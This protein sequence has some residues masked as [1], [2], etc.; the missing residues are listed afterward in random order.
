M[1]RKPLALVLVGL[2][3]LSASMAGCRRSSAAPPLEELTTEEEAAAVMLEA[4]ANTEEMEQAAVVEEAPAATEELAE[5]PAET[6]AETPEPA[7]EAEAASEPAVT[8]APVEPATEEPAAEPVTTVGTDAT[9]HVVQ[10]GENLFQI[11]LRYAITVQAISQANN[12]TNPGLI[13]VGQTLQIPGG[14]GTTA[15]TTTP[16]QTCA[17]VYV[18]Q[19]GDNLFRI[20]LSYDYSQYYLAEYNGLANASM[21]YVGQ[22]LCIP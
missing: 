11:S 18:V 2:M 1:R 13:Y 6:E 21:V 14:S 19:P 17:T 4:Q 5:A 22:Q 16:G 3:I 20:A 7:E 12:I 10:P 8:T 9:T 15:P